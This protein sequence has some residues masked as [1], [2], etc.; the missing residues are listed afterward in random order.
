M[1]HSHWE[2]ACLESSTDSLNSTASL[3]KDF[4]FSAFSDYNGKLKYNIDPS[5]SKLSNNSSIF[6]LSLTSDNFL[7]LF[8]WLSHFALNQT[9]V[10]HVSEVVK[11]AIHAPVGRSIKLA[12]HLQSIRCPVFVSKVPFKKVNVKAITGGSKQI[13][14]KQKEFS[15]TGELKKLEFAT[16][17]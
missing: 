13:Y 14:L 2:V 11:D 1:N 8:R 17:I 6:N 16:L 3:I 15:G 4:R 9:K 5:P 12:T 10:T 7:S